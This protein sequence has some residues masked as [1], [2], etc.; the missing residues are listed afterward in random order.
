M[1]FAVLILVGQKGIEYL[2]ETE[3]PPWTTKHGEVRLFDSFVAAVVHMARLGMIPNHAGFGN[4]YM[5][6]ARLDEHKRSF[7]IMKE[8]D[9][10]GRMTDHEFFALYHEVVLLRSILTDDTIS[11]DCL[12]E[13]VTDEE[14]FRKRE[15]TYEE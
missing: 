13:M 4:Q 8:L 1:K 5:P 6:Q 3:E 15:D 11:W 9:P 7:Q 12:I 14:E 10:D 2:A